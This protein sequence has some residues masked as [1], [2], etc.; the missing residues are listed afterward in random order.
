MFEKQININGIRIYKDNF[1]GLAFSRLTKRTDYYSLR[2]NS[3]KTSSSIDVFD[4]RYERCKK[5]YE[6]YIRKL[7]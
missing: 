7:N 1:R 2:Y 4:S 6:K 5:V 3:N